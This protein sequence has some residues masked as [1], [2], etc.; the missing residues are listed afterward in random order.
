[1]H[2]GIARAGCSRPK[3][4]KRRFQYSLKSLVIASLVAGALLGA[5]FV[6]WGIWKGRT[7][8]VEGLSNPQEVTGWT[9]QGLQLA[10]GRTIALP[11]I[12]ELPAKSVTLNF[13]VKHGVELQGDRA[14]TLIEIYHWCGNDPVRKHWVRADLAHA[15]RFTQE[16]LPVGEGD[17]AKWLPNPLGGQYLQRRRLWDPSA[18]YGFKQ[19][20]E[21]ANQPAHEAK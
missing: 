14:Y 6:A 10:D 17:R 20:E 1:M 5:G 21:R 4:A 2:A 13:A 18:Y 16:I 12:D 11:G 15:L 3:P 7:E 9:A 19:Q 8:I